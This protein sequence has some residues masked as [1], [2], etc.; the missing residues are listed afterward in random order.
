MRAFLQFVDD[1][2]GEIMILLR[3]HSNCFNVPGECGL[4]AS[5][6]ASTGP[7]RLRISAAVETIIGSSPIEYH[8]RAIKF[9]RETV[10]TYWRPK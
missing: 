10:K 1:S 9:R 4:P 2:H 7:Q 6:P 8:N 3:G 5:P